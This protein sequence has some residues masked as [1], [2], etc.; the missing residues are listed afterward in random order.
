[1]RW[2]YLLIFVPTITIWMLNHVQIFLMGIFIYNPH[3]ICCAMGMILRTEFNLLWHIFQRQV[4]LYL[5]MGTFM[6]KLQSRPVWVFRHMTAYSL[7]TEW[8]IYIVCSRR[9]PQFSDIGGLFGGPTWNLPFLACV[10]FE[11]F[12]GGPWFGL[13]GACLS[14]VSCYFENINDCRISS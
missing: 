2:T 3:V 13:H 10:M 4:Y 8:K 6:N 11:G 5:G 12:H 14:V 1:M 9:G 7:S